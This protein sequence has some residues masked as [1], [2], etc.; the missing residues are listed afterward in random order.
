MGA[1]TSDSSPASSR[2]ILGPLAA[3]S[4]DVM[5]LYTNGVGFVAAASVDCSEC[6]RARMV[7]NVVAIGEMRAEQQI[8]VGNDRKNG[9]GKSNGAR[10]VAV[11]HPSD[12]DKYVARMGHPRWFS[13]PKKSNRGCDGL[14]VSVGK[15]RY[16][17]QP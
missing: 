9:K 10:G 16:R 7:E 4:W 12:K 11:S 3:R 2:D 5:P 6:A 17:S 13:W 14:L 1:A 15:E 8:S